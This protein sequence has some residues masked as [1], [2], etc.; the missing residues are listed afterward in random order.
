MGFTLEQGEREMGSWTLNYLP[1]AGGRYT[2]KLVVTD[3]RLL[4]DARFDTSVTGALKELIIFEGSHGYIAI[5][6]S[7]IKAV[8]VRSG[9]MSKR[10][11]V[12]LNDGSQHTF[13]Y[14]MLSVKKLAEAIEQR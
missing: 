12:T 1:P 11:V 4:F 8:E 7:A 3:R 2:G 5:A 6:K 10:V 13:D 14:G 9:M